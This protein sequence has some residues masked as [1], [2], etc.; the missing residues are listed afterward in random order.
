[1]VYATIKADFHTASL[2]TK[3]NETHADL[4]TY[5]LKHTYVRYLNQASSEYIAF[6][7]TAHKTEQ[8]A[9]VY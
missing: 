8:C 2:A 6:L 9:R 5:F 7:D 3:Y 4:N 1:M